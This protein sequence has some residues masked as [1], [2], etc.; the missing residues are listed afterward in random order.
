VSLL[1][2]EDYHNF[3]LAFLGIICFCK[4]ILYFHKTKGTETFSRSQNNLNTTDNKMRLTE[5]YSATTKLYKWMRGNWKFVF[6]IP[7]VCMYIFNIF[8]PCLV[9][10]VCNKSVL[11]VYIYC[12]IEG[13]L[14]WNWLLRNYEG[15]WAW[16]SIPIIPATMGGKRQETWMFKASLSKVKSPYL[17]KQNKKRLRAWLMW[18]NAC[19]ASLRTWVQSP[20]PQEK[21]KSNIEYMVVKKK[22]Y[23]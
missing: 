8:W 14:K 17:K 13:T 10:S 18:Q 6:E 11:T 4:G 15:K 2:W 9:K 21:N 16:W 3:Y 20:V 22:Y 5:S 12:F 23:Y 7:F 19:L 1:T